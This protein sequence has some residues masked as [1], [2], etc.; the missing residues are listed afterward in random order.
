MF[1]GLLGSGS[2]AGE[3]AVPLPISL[4]ASAAARS[5]YPAP[6]VKISYWLV[7]VT[8]VWGSVVLLVFGKFLL[9]VFISRAFTWSGVNVGCCCKTSAT[10]P[11]TTPAAILVPL[12]TK[13][14]PAAELPP[15]M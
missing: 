9:A 2:A 13:Y 15:Y 12:R 4:L 11:L 5:R 3:S 1:P 6:I 7:Y 14:G 10:A 8:P